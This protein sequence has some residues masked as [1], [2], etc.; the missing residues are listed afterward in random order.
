MSDE[1]TKDATTAAPDPTGNL[2]TL[3]T[4]EQVAAT[5]QVNPRTIRRWIEADYLVTHRFG[6]GYRVS[7]TDLQAFIRLGRQV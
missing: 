3:L 6:R 7:E 5:L 4:I 2:P 1:N